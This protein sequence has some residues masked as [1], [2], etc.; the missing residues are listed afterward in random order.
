MTYLGDQNQCKKVNFAGGDL[1]RGMY[2]K[3]TF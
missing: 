2:S 1:N 3:S